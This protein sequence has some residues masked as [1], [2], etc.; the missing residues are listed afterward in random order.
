MP[1]T[2]ADYPNSMKNLPEKVRNKA[3]DIA[4]ALLKEKGNMGEGI[5]IATS[6]S[7]AKD[8]AVNRGLKIKSTSKEAKTTDVKEHGKDRYVVP[9]GEKEWAVKEERAKRVEKVFKSKNAA[10]KR[11]SEEAKSANAGVTIQ[12]RTGKVEKRI[13]YNPKRRVKKLK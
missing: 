5:I 7:R 11:A 13:S 1:W 10:V 12:K 4:D 6:I 9:H 2:K 3:I 8:W